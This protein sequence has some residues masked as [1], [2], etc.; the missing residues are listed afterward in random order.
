[1]PDEGS[2]KPRGVTCPSTQLVLRAAQSSWRS[3]PVFFGSSLTVDDNLGCWQ[4][5]CRLRGG[6]DPV[7]ISRRRP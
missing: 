3:P 5:D 2:G 4:A 1:M 6:N 7:S